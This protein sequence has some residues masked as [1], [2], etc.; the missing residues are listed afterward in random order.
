MIAIEKTLEISPAALYE[1]GY[2]ALQAANKADLTGT[3]LVDCRKSK[4]APLVRVTM[5][6]CGAIYEFQDLADFPE[7]SL[8]CKCD[9]ERFIVVRY[10]EGN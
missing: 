4:T 6:C 1:E 2:V 8:P 5:P 7:K 9:D 3:R 10:E